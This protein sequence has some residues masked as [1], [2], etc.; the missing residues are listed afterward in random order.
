M[1][2]TG[3]APMKPDG[4]IANPV[5]AAVLEKQLFAA[6]VCSAT[7][8]ASYANPGVAIAYIAVADTIII[9]ILR[10][11]NLLDPPPA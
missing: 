4:L 11:N 5:L 3:I 9:L 10:M 2:G 8:W 6:A 1:K 7:G